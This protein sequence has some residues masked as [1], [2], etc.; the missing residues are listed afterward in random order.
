MSQNNVNEAEY[1][2]LRNL[3]RFYYA[4][5]RYNLAAG[6]AGG[7]GKVPHPDAKDRKAQYPAKRLA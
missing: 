7:V 4:Q 3:L 6:G 1:E 5:Y 2:K